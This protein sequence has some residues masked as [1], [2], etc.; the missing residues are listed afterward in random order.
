MSHRSGRKQGAEFF[1]PLGFRV[2]VLFAA[3][4]IIAMLSNSL[5]P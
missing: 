5:L 1:G 3:V 2:A 4:F